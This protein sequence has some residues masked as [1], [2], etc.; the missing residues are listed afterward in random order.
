MCQLATFCLQITLVMLGVSHFFSL[1]SVW[2]LTIA[3]SLKILPAIIS[4][5]METLFSDRAIVSDLYMETLF[6]SR[7]IVND[8]TL[9][10]S[11]LSSDRERPNGN[12]AF[13]FQ[14]QQKKT[15]SHSSVHFAKVSLL[16]KI[17]SRTSKRLLDGGYNYW[18]TVHKIWHFACGFAGFWG[19]KMCD[20]LSNC[21][22]S[23][24]LTHSPIFIFL[25]FS[26]S[27]LDFLAKTFVK[28]EIKLVWP[29][30]LIKLFWGL[31]F[32]ISLKQHVMPNQTFCLVLSCILKA[33]FIYQLREFTYCFLEVRNV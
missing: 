6:S 13:E 30:Q 33:K 20:Q 7:A 27:D 1:V 5:C 28:Q 23:T 32:E 18:Y 22:F 26:S 3:R 25:F 4:D 12:K 31:N 2:S 14:C 8:P 9:E 16:S 11:Q 15:V 24:W 29:H 21:P 17:K 10:W 19:T